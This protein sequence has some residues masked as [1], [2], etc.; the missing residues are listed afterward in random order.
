MSNT[1]LAIIELDNTP[2]D[3]ARR[4]AWLARMYDCKLH[5][6]LSD[7]SLAILRDS[8]I[9]SNEAKE[10]ALGIEDAQRRVLADL[11]ETISSD[12]SLDVTTDISH[13]R[14]AHDAIIGRAVDIEP[15]FVVKGTQYHSAA[16][17]AT[18]AYTDWQ[19]IRK[20][21]APLWFVKPKAWRD[22]PVIVAAVDPT[23]QHDKEGKLDQIIVTMGK[24]VASRCDGQL[25]LLHT[26]QRL[27][28]IGT[29]A[30]LKFKPVKLPIDELDKKI[31][32]DH[33]E[34]LEALASANDIPEDAVHQLPGRTRDLLPT[35]ARTHGA[36][37][38]IMGALARAGL[39]RRTIGSTAEQVLDHL[40]CDILIA[41]GD[42]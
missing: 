6:L 21:N 7:P 22:K 28:E 17:R 5:L 32:K 4:A 2:E 40:Q 27:V 8:F 38:V 25:L 37:L 14:P 11:S 15:R 30:K 33:R 20:L 35:F 26:Y 3:V 23:H 9:V 24:D 34:K 36:D 39:R 19:L 18:F 29:Y 12:G 10:V 16:E 42:D 31:R 13:D 1:V 41:R